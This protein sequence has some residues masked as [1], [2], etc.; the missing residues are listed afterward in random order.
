[1]VEIIS[2]DFPMEEIPPPTR[3][4]KVYRPLYRALLEHGRL[5][6]RVYNPE[7]QA[8]NSTGHEAYRIYNAMGR[9]LERNRIPKKLSGR[10]SKDILWLWLVDR[11]ED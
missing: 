1:M 2:T 8:L 5:K 10:L 9:W 7:N 11:K 3:G 6:L 4:K